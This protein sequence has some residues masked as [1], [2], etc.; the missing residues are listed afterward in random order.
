MKPF[1]NSTPSAGFSH[2]TKLAL[3]RGNS[4]TV[5][6]QE[7]SK[8]ELEEQVK[9]GTA[10]ADIYY[11][12]GLKT[13]ERAYFA[14]TVELNPNHVQARFELARDLFTEGDGNPAISQEALEHINKVIEL[15]PDC[16]DAYELRASL[17]W[18]HFNDTERALADADY[19][20]KH[21]PDHKEA[22]Q[23][24]QDIEKFSNPEIS[25]ALTKP[26]TVREWLY[27][28]AVVA[29]SV[30]FAWWFLP[31]LKRTLLNLVG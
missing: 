14:K 7:C 3:F 22:L 15:Q 21:Q 9:L 12:L 26:I 24:K 11:L 16:W 29:F 27:L 30:W 20:L 19:I 13:F 25:E 8:K 28:A 17:Y 6:M 18:T 2:A 4:Y 23:L 31:W 5:H 1:R 10:N